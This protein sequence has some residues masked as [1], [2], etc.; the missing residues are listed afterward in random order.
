MIEIA[1]YHLNKENKVLITIQDNGE[2]IDDELRDKIFVPN[3]STKNSGMGLGLA[4]V[5]KIIE[6]SDGSIRFES[7]PGVGTTF[8][9]ELPL[10][11]ME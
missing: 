8:Y 5:K 10:T 6:H 11:E 3:F 1:T 9:V 7:I 4:M 2:G